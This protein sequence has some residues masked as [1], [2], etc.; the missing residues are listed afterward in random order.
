MSLTL[1][2][3]RRRVAASYAAYRS[4]LDR[5][6]AVERWRAERDVLLHEHPDGPLRGR[7]PVPYAPVT[8]TGRHE[9]EVDVDVPPARLDVPTASDGVVVLDRLGRLHVP[10]VGDLDVWWLG[11]YGGG[12]FVPLRDASAGRTTCGGGRSLLDTV[13]GA[14]LGDDVDSVSGRGTLV[15]VLDLAYHPSC[16]YDARWSCPLAPPGDVVATAV[17]AGE[18]LPPGGWGAPG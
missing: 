11:Q 5:E 8:P 6:A 10:D 14:D 13:K 9:L 4:F 3:H 12:V 2:D 16:T 7:P 18:Q 15:V 1:L 17:D